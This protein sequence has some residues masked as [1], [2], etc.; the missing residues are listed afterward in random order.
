[1][2]AT[3][4]VVRRP[5]DWSCIVRVQTDTRLGWRTLYRY[6]PDCRRACRNSILILAIEL[7]PEWSAKSRQRPFRGVSFRGLERRIVYLAWGSA[8]ALSCSVPL[9]N[10][11]C[12]ISLNGDA[13]FREVD[14]EERAPVL[15]RQHTPRINCLAAPRIETEDPIGFGDR[16]PSL[17]I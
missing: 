9:A 16:I 11:R 5:W 12:S 8:T 14:S 6:R 1:M 10:N 4:V 17:N 13:H 7:K 15:A 3:A 2:V